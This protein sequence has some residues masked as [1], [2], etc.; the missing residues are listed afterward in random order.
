M[1]LNY[2][3]NYFFFPLLLLT[4]FSTRLTVS[5]QL[6]AIAT[7]AFV[8]SRKISTKLSARFLRQAFVYVWEEMHFFV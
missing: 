1:K 7:V 2:E 8:F 3:V 5:L 6:K 4:I